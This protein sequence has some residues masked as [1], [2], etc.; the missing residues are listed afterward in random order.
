[1]SAEGVA[2]EKGLRIGLL[3]WPRQKWIGIGI[4]IFTGKEFENKFIR[5]MIS[6]VWG[7]KLEIVW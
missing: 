5:I 3:N 4:Q 6:F 2:M 1:M 7:I